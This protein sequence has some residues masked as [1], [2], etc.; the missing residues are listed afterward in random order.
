LTETGRV[1]IDPAPLLQYMV[2]TDPNPLQASVK[3]ALYVNISN[4][5]PSRPIR[6]FSIAISFSIGAAAA[7]LTATPNGIRTPAPR[8]WSAR[9]DDG[10][11]YR[12]KPDGTAGV[13][14]TSAGISLEILE[15]AVNGQVGTTV[16]D[17]D[18]TAS[19][20][21]R[22]R[23]SRST[24]ATLGKFP[25]RFRLSDL[26]V[27]P[28]PVVSGGA[29]VLGWLGS[30]MP[31][32]V[33]YKLT[34]TSGGSPQSRAVTFSG[35]ET[36]SGVDTEP[37]TAFK[38][39]ASVAGAPDVTRPALVNVLPRAPV[40]DYFRG[41]VVGNQVFL[42]WSASHAEGCEIEGLSASLPAKG[43]RP[44]PIDRFRYTLT[45][46]NKNKTTKA[47]VDIKIKESASY[48]ADERRWESLGAL[49]D[50][51][52]AIAMAGFREIAVFDG[53]TM[54][55]RDTR[56][57]IGA[58]GSVASSASGNRTLLWGGRNG[59][60]AHLYDSA[61]NIIQ[62]PDGEEILDAAFSL[63]GSWIYVLHASASGIRMRKHAAGD[64]TRISEYTYD[65]GAS[66]KAGSVLAF[67]PRG[68]R[69]FVYSSNNPNGGTML[70]ID[71]STGTETRRAPFGGPAF[72]QNS[73]LCWQSGTKLVLS[74]TRSLAGTTALGTML[75][76]T[77]T[78]A[79]MRDLPWYPIAL[80]ARE[81]VGALQRGNERYIE[82]ADNMTFEVQQSILTGRHFP[83]NLRAIVRVSRAIFVAQPNSG[84]IIRYEG[85]SVERVNL[86]LPA[87][88]RTTRW[89][90][91]AMRSDSLLVVV[92]TPPEGMLID[93]TELEIDVAGD[94]VTA[95]APEGWSVTGEGERFTF[96]RTDDVEREI[97]AFAFRDAGDGAIRVHETARRT[98]ELG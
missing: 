26:S 12:A 73:I 91:Q 10:G 60:V 87:S 78:F 46:R 77:D 23:L 6:L 75:I 88:H 44:F 8:G 81:V 38:L 41:N 2:G 65:A 59:P 28:D 37:Q 94:G 57:I 62:H 18:E 71:P 7:D 64:F 82:I 43:E 92:A 48:R 90:Y 40:I 53:V 16:I 3:G 93:E 54:R 30:N 72:F 32:L 52:L 31:G 83:S 29:V 45:A 85:Q 49:P 5:D 66:A 24:S 17:I 14:I 15:I 1:T 27:T 97:L 58:A 80:T 69:I 21:T 76:D 39:I 22:P 20:A 34:W 70:Q 11:V 36:I 4:P 89:H 33:S 79:V 47:A 68:D 35:P 98:L 56:P 86:P 96:R 67:S 9:F 13:D 19:D 61:F 63:D 74:M 55:R 25:A 50:G 51:S 84:S 95:E 42:E